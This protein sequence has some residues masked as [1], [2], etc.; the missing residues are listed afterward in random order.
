[1]DK[2]NNRADNLE[3]VTDIENKRKAREIKQ[4]KI[5]VK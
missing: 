5:N 2:T 1:M 4:S 3:W